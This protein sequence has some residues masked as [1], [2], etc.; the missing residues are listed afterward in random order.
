MGSSGVIVSLE[1]LI[2]SS[3][4][5]LII[6]SEELQISR[7]ELELLEVSVELLL[8]MALLLLFAL[9]LE[10]CFTAFFFTQRF[11]C[12]SSSPSARSVTL[13]S[14]GLTRT[15]LVCAP[16]MLV[17]VATMFVLVLSVVHSVWS[18]VYPEGACIDCMSFPVL[19]AIRIL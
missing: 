7:S 8:K 11:G 6:I 5:E 10:L 1:L 12:H 3:E 14:S 15:I 2:T 16:F 18:N 4:L 17:R 13:L 9:L 19:S